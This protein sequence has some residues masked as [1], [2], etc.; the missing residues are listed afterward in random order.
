MER[1]LLRYLTWMHGR[2]EAHQHD[3]YRCNGCRR[4]VTWHAI[5]KGGCT[6]GENRMRATYLQ[7]WEKLRLILFPWWCV[8]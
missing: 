7:W 3:Y 1:L 4:I 8:R 5:R 6:C 2:G